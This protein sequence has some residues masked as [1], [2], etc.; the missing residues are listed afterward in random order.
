MF[1]RGL[2]SDETEKPD[3]LKNEIDDQ[4]R[5]AQNKNGNSKESTEHDCDKSKENHVS[6]G[7]TQT[8]NKFTHF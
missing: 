8:R 4:I 2:Q 7:F 6:V 1:F 5:N 3:S